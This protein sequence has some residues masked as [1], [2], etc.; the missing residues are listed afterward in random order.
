MGSAYTLHVLCIGFVVI[1][2]DLGLGDVFSGSPSTLVADA[3]AFSSRHLTTFSLSRWC[4]CFQQREKNGAHEA[5]VAA[6][7]KQ[8]EVRRILRLKVAQ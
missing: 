7:A 1:C 2:S 6:Q 8:H 3:R 4:S 5:R